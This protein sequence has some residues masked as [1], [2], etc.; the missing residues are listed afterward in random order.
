MVDRMLEEKDRIISYCLRAMSHVLANNCRF[1]PCRVADE[2]KNDW[3]NTPIDPHSFELF[4]SENITLTGNPQ[5]EVFALELYEHYQRYC[6]SENLDII[7]YNNIKQWIATNIPS[8]EC[9]HKRIHRTNENP[10]SGFTGIKFNH[11]SNQTV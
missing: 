5:D 11:E 2:M 7:P 10:K 6:I 1:S 4:W 9:V 3:R 8:D